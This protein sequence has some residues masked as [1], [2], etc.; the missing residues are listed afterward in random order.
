MRPSDRENQCLPHVLIVDDQ[1]DSVTALKYALEQQGYRVTVAVDGNQAIAFIEV[2]S[3]DLVLLDVMMPKR[4]GFMV[5]EYLRGTMERH[6]PIVMLTA[7]DGTRHR[8]YA[9][10]LGVDD[11]VNKPYVIENLLK[12][13]RNLIEKNKREED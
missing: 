4:S 6:I 13:V 5:L 3:P 1:E 10:A 9:N 7:V 12:T 2:A 11:Y 8:K